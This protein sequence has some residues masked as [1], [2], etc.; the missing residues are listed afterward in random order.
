MAVE[1]LVLLDNQ[2][3]PERHWFV[4]TPRIGEE[5]AL[6]GGV[7]AVVHNITHLPSPEGVTNTPPTIQLHVTNRISRDRHR[8]R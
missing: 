4:S 7:T 1:C 8:S 6:Q 2:N 5:I 3:D